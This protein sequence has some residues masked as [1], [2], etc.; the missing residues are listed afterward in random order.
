M[1]EG[2]VAEQI[3]VTVR[4]S[5]GNERTERV[6]VAQF[7]GYMR[8][9]GWTTGSPAPLGA[10]RGWWKPTSA[11]HLVYRI[12]VGPV[13]DP[14]K[15]RSQMFAHC[16]ADIAEIEQRSVFDVLRDI[17]SESAR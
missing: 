17:A 12:N 2:L 1:D 15:N 14:R 8:R 16:V 7:E 9:T 5:D 3:E 10:V 6:S 13:I 4:G 11:R